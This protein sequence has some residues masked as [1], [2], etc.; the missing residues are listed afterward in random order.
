[1]VLI[2]LPKCDSDNMNLIKERI[3]NNKKKINESNIKPYPI[4][5]SYGSSVQYP[6]NK[7]LGLDGFINYADKEMSKQKKGKK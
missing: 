5:F 7:K 2:I 6:L 4:S 1:M 3:D